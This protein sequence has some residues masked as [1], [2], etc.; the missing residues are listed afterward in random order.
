MKNKST[1]VTQKTPVCIPTS[2][3][4]QT[5]AVYVTLFR[6]HVVVHHVITFVN[7]AWR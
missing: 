5:P 6:K 4:G 2:Q 7:S 3:L 1:L